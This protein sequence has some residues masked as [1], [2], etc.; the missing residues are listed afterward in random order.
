MYDVELRIQQDQLKE[1][2]EL[3]PDNYTGEDYNAYFEKYVKILRFED[4]GNGIQFNTNSGCIFVVF[5]EESA[6]I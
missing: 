6:V 1:C 2:L 5:V 4:D 3:N